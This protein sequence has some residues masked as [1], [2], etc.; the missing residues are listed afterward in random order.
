MERSDIR[1]SLPHFAPLN[2][3]YALT[4]AYG[5]IGFSGR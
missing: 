5:N 4:Y 1:D 2:G 3:G